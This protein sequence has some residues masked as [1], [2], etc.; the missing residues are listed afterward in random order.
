[1]PRIF[2]AVAACCFLAACGNQ[3][4]AEQIT[5][6]NQVQQRASAQILLLNVLRA[7]V[8]EPLA[9]SRLD[10]LRGSNDLSGGIAFNLPFGPNNGGGRAAAPFVSADVGT[11]NDLAPQDDQDF[12]RGI[13]TPVTPETWALY[14][15]QNWP[16]DILFHLFVEDI[17]L[18]EDD[19]HRL[20]GDV[21]AFCGANGGVEEV[22]QQ[23]GL[24]RGIESRVSQLGADC[25]PIVHLLGGRRIYEL[26]NDPGN[27]CALWQFE[28]FTH[29]LL[30]MGF[31]ITKEETD[32][33]IGPVMANGTKIGTFDWPFKLK[34][35]ETKLKAVPGG[36]Q[37]VQ[38]LSS[39]A[40]KL[41][42]LPCPASANVA[43]AAQSELSAASNKLNA[44]SAAAANAQCPANAA[45]NIA[46]TTRS[47]DGIV[48]YLG[49]VARAAMPIDARKPPLTVE[50]FTSSSGAQHP[51]INIV[52]DD[53]SDDAIVHVTFEGADYIVPRGGNDLT[54]QI[55][56]LLQQIFALYNKAPSAPATTAVTVVP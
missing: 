2:A 44:R 40:V 55:F 52:R 10:V 11:S 12:Y 32:I 34:D 15:D 25:A 53:F 7:R 5:E 56:E 19:Y 3:R 43:V 20:M 47:P 37:F 4:M 33:A 36:I 54:M 31:H 29:A 50:V 9:Y 35:G 27:R 1:M 24:F 17:K 49:E 42:N 30:I 14:Q 51:L 26:S 38:V 41:A 28:A 46:I 16:P 18:P 39:Y 8:K 21:H 22:L 6:L 13:L 48:Y 23:C 45:I